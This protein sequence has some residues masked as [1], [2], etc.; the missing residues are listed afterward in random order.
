M[1]QREGR[2]MMMKD[3]MMM[4]TPETMGTMMEMMHQNEMM[5]EDRMESCKKK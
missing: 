3:S 2:K 1:M 4:I 5:S